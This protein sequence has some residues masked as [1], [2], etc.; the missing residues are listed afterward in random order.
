MAAKLAA[1]LSRPSH[2]EAKNAAP[3]PRHKGRRHRPR[4]P[5]AWASVRYSAGRV[6]LRAHA[7]SVLLLKLAASGPPKPTAPPLGPRLPS[8]LPSVPGVT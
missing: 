6:L 7:Y 1:G 3:T 4:P 2:S 5:L 8:R